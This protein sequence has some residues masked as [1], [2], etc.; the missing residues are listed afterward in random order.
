VRHH[1]EAYDAV[2]AGQSPAQRQL[3][4]GI[5]AGLRFV[6]GQASGEAHLG[7]FIA[8]APEPGAGSERITG[9]RWKPAP[10]PVLV[11]LPPR[12][13]AWEMTRYQAYQDRLAGRTIGEIFR[14]AAAFL[15][16]TAAN[17]GS[18]TDLANADAP[19]NGPGQPQM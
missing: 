10:L 5:L 7:E 8:A 11:S 19:D 3:T 6:R 15:T 2:L 4:E 12:A 18:L 17:A 16:L 14:L 13:Q 9:W 1:P